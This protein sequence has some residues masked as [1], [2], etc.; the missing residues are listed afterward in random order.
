[1]TILMRSKKIFSILATIAAFNKIIV[2][3]S[4]YGLANY[5]SDLIAA[6]G[7]AQAHDYCLLSNPRERISVSKR[8]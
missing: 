7:A 2:S 1:M 3:S 5:K 8:F 6:V 4:A